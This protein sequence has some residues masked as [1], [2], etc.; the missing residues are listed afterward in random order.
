M[1]TSS[2]SAAGTGTSCPSPLITHDGGNSENS[3]TVFLSDIVSSPYLTMPSEAAVDVDM[4][5]ESG[6]SQVTCLWAGCLQEFSSLTQLVVHLDRCHTLAMTQ[7]VCH[8]ESC[9]RQLKPFDARY[10]LTTH[11]RCHTGEKPYQCEVASCKRSF[12]R[13]ENLKLHTR[14]HTGEKPYQ[15]HH[16]GCIKRFNNTSDRAKHMKTHITRKPYAC[17]HPGCNKSYTDPS[18][19]RKHIKYTHKLKEEIEEGGLSLAGLPRRKRNSTSCSSSSSSSSTPHTPQQNLQTQQQ[20]QGAVLLHSP[21]AAPMNDT[22][23]PV[24]QPVSLVPPGKSSPVSMCSLSGCSTLINTSSAPHVI[25]VVKLQGNTGK[26][27]GLNGQPLLVPAYQQPSVMM[28]VPGNFSQANSSV[29]STVPSTSA[30]FTS[31]VR[32]LPVSTVSSQTPSQQKP[33]HPI[34]LAASQVPPTTLQTTH[35]MQQN[36]TNTNITASTT[37]SSLSVEDQLRLQIAHL[38]Q[39]LYQS[40]LAAAAA[41]ATAIPQQTISSPA[42]NSAH[43]VVFLNNRKLNSQPDGGEKGKASSTLPEGSGS[44]SVHKTNNDLSRAGMFPEMQAS[45]QL[46]TNPVSAVQ[47]MGTSMLS[48]SSV[49]LPLLNA[50]GRSAGGGQGPILVSTSSI[51]VLGVEPSSGGRGTP[52]SISSTPVLSV[53]GASGS[54]LPQFIPIPIIHTKG[55]TPNTQFIYMSS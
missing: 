41:A 24:L 47:H 11:L 22:T 18:S 45:P 51:P 23:K 15:C 25:P 4:E 8:W 7:Y 21:P 13:L 3:S 46:A 31:P 55:M 20:I 27:T 34:L 35:P 5:D 2:S 33:I 17:K 10:K 49:S 40:Q 26:V 16:T 12:S 6:D 53:G 28:I 1:P 38:R 54:V 39:Q 43:P 50:S 29:G 48:S 30:S 19:M 52:V 14:T 9:P 44:S 37:A 36:Q 42:L 32:S